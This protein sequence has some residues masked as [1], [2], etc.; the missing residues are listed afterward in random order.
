M[1]PATPPYRIK[2]RVA[3]QGRVWE[4][5]EFT[6]GIGDSDLAGSAA[7]TIG[8]PRPRIVAKVVSKLLDLDDLGGVIGAPPQAGPGETASPKQ[9]AASARQAAGA[10]LLPAKEFNLAKLRA[11]DADIEF[12]GKSI[13]GRTPVDDLKLHATLVDGV[14]TT[15]PLNFGVAGGDVT[16]R[17]EMNARGK[18]IRTSANIEFK[19]IDLH[20]LFPNNRLAAQT[21]GL[22]GGRA[23]LA[24][25][26]N[27]VA[28]MLA[29][30]DGTF[31]LATA[32]GTVSNLLLELVGLDA[33]EVLNRLF[34]GDKQVTMRCAVADFEVKGGVMH[35]RS[36]VVDTSDTNINV[37]GTIDLRDETLDLTIHPLPKDYSPLAL[38]TPLHVKG[39]FKK[40]RV[41]P[42]GKLLL[43]G[44]IAVVLGALVGPLAALAAAA[45]NRARRRRRL[46]TPDA[47]PRSDT[48]APGRPRPDAVG[49][50][51]VAG[52][53]TSA[54]P[55]PAS[56][57]CARRGGFATSAR[58][59][60][61]ARPA[62]PGAHPRSRRAAGLR[63]RVD[64]PPTPRGHLQ[65]TG[66]RRPRAQAVPLS[67]ALARRPRRRQVR[68]HA[69]VRRR[70]AAPAPPPGARP[71]AARACR[72][73]R[74]VATLVAR[75]S[76]TPARASATP[77]TRA[78]TAPT[79]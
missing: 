35:T 44:G 42:D 70:A 69:R 53:P 74:V 36:M 34:R 54:T 47:R 24:G 66:A 16:S 21:T 50:A 14:L 48:P 33:A 51:A 31:G 73:H 20:K 18:Q 10:T 15:D 71:R 11:M 29:S 55:R 13:R 41:R 58:R 19:R 62:D 2:G 60:S 63:R 77:S 75:C 59:P 40:P 49:R 12:T 9:A 8:E 56:A 7:V 78:T 46:R 37:A 72:A 64:L 1:L 38:R 65:A 17:I 4:M 5:K 30:A 52:S 3:H 79:G 76:I 39:R 57:G 67:P 68:A 6:G 23:K 26:G 61:A 27:S 28:Q 25:E 32:G 43:R 22:V 45:R